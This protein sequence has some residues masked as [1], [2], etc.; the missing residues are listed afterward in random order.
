MVNNT[1]HMHTTPEE[2]DNTSVTPKSSPQSRCLF[3]VGVSLLSLGI[4]L[5]TATKVDAVVWVLCIVFGAFSCFWDP[6][7]WVDREDDILD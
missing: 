3:G 2:M 6:C 5:S 1:K 7:K 4:I